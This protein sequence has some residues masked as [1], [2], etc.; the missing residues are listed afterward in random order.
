MHSIGCSR[1]SR[2]ALNRLLMKKAHLSGTRRNV[3][4]LDLFGQ[5]GPE[6]VF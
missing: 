1:A 6:R 3:L 2:L 5:P 4:H